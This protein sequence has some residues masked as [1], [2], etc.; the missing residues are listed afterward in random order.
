MQHKDAE[1][2]GR[3]FQSVNGQLSMFQ[4]DLIKDSE[5]TKDT[6]VIHG[7]PE[8][9]IYGKGIR[10]NPRLPGR[11][12]SKYME[13][14]YLP[15]LLPLE[16]YDLIVVLLSGGKDSIACYYKLQELG[17]PKSKIELWHHS[18]DGGHPSR[19]MDWRCTQ[20]SNSFGRMKKY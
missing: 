9:P 2:Y 19:H 20:A 8:F 14:I 11:K 5:C 16:Q 7:K 6:P 10:I 4:P 13:K 15:E 1:S 3:Y 17:V 12:D 18:I